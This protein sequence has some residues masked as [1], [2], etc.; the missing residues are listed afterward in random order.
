MT[1][2]ESSRNKYLYEEKLPSMSNLWL[3]NVYIQKYEEEMCLFSDMQ[4]NMWKQSFSEEM[5]CVEE[6]AEIQC[7]QW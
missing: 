4:C 6:E 2:Y 5:K 7:N 1:V 3:I